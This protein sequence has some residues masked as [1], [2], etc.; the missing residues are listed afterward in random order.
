MT[1]RTS[2]KLQFAAVTDRIATRAA[3]YQR[4]RKRLNC[5]HSRYDATVAAHVAAPR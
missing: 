1:T 2:I 3:A 5:A 4:S